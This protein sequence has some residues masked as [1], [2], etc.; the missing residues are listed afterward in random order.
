MFLDFF[1]ARVPIGVIFCAKYLKF[2][3]FL[4]GCAGKCPDSK[5]L[6]NLPPPRS[7]TVYINRPIQ[8]TH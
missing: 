2:S 4:D 5:F 3:G 1:S 7:N 6:A 8:G